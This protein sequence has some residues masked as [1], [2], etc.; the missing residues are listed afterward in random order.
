MTLRKLDKEHMRQLKDLKQI[1]RVLDDRINECPWF[2]PVMKNHLLQVTN[3]VAEWARWDKLG[4]TIDSPEIQPAQREDYILYKKLLDNKYDLL[5]DI[6]KELEW[7][8]IMLSKR[9]ITD[10]QIETLTRLRKD[11]KGIDILDNAHYLNGPASV[12]ESKGAAQKVKNFIFAL[13]GIPEEPEPIVPRTFYLASTSDNK[14]DRAGLPYYYK[15]VDGVPDLTMEV[16]MTDQAKGM[17]ARRYG[18]GPVLTHEDIVKDEIRQAKIRDKQTAKFL[19][20]RQKQRDKFHTDRTK[21][22]D[23]VRAKNKELIKEWTEEQRI[24]RENITA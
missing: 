9:T 15:M 6:R 21:E 22:R 1:F 11:G 18:T 3:H 13:R 16:S 17:R 4:W 7:I 8:H 2:A 12:F 10:H 5:D 24:R 19:D 20:K 23:L 14:T